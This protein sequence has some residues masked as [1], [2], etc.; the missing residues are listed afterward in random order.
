M[1]SQKT[2]WITL[3]CLFSFAQARGGSLQLMSYNVENLF[4]AVHDEGKEDWEFLPK[5]TPGKK[6]FCDSISNATNKKKCNET[7]WTSEK[8]DLK[9]EQIKRVI[10][11]RPSAPDL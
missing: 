9:I 1:G 5:G 10:G 7:D 11:A 6:A 2:F 3:V 8:V 4:D